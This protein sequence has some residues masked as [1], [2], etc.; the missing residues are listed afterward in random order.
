MLR[1][2]LRNMHQPPYR[3]G[4]AQRDAVR[5]RCYVIDRQGGPMAVF[6]LVDS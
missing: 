4:L 6:E 2:E 1:A 5:E 3:L